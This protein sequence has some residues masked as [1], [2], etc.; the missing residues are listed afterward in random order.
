MTARPAR[1][2]AERNADDGMT[3]IELMVS[4]AVMATVMALATAG[5]IAMFRSSDRADAA[6]TVQQRIN[7]AFDRLDREIRYAKIINKPLAS[8]GPDFAVTY[9]ISDPKTNVDTCVQLWLK[10]DQTGPYK[11]GD[12]QLRHDQ[13]RGP[14]RDHR[15]DHPVQRGGPGRGSGRQDREQLR[16]AA[17][18]GHHQGRHAG[19]PG[20]DQQHPAAALHR[21][22][23]RQRAGTRSQRRR[24]GLHGTPAVTDDRRRAGTVEGAMSTPDGDWRIEVVRRGT[25]RWYRIVHGD[26]VQDWLSITAVERILAEAGVD[27]DSLVDADPG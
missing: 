19:H 5:L 9:V 12:R 24:L 10:D 4:M 3:M 25:S 17:D 13:C 8:T 18:P 23:H 6:A 15:T 11:R 16:P 2:R 20:Q 1:R 21:P 22:E 7:G 14:T 27:R 26:D